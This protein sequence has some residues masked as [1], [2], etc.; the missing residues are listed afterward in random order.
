MPHKVQVLIHP[1]NRRIA[2][3]RS[4]EKRHDVEHREQRHEAEVDF[5]QDPSDLFALVVGQV[6]CVDAFMA[7]LVAGRLPPFFD[8]LD[9][10][11]DLLILED[12]A[13]LAGHGGCLCDGKGGRGR[14]RGKKER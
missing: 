9:D 14:E 10:A 11:L 7:V 12:G 13:V 4:I 2:Q 6:L 8:V 5:A 1:S 3:I